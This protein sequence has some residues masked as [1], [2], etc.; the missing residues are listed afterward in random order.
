[1]FDYIFNSVNKGCLLN[2]VFSSS[3]ILTASAS[4]ARMAGID[5]PAMSSGG[6]GNQGIVAILVP[7][8]AGKIFK[9]EEKIILQSIALSHLMNSYIK[10]F[11]GDLSPL[12]GCA[13]AEGACAAVALV[14]QQYGKDMEKITLAVNSLISDLGGML[15][16]GAKG[17]CA[18]KVATATDSAIR[19][20]YMAL[21]NYGISHLEGF[22]G[23]T[24]EETIYNLSK[25]SILSMPKVNETILGIMLDKR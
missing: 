10:C 13:T 19:C 3:K 22:V 9:I 8:N 7:Y 4:D 20:A 24:A 11:T 15:C 1:M 21:D 18:L 23:K 25:I 2:D 17:G 5:L 14:Y 16:D 6:S 12:C